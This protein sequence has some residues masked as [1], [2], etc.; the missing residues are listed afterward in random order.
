MSQIMDM[1]VD[2]LRPAIFPRTVVTEDGLCLTMFQQEF[3]I[4][5]PFFSVCHEFG[6]DY[7]W[8]TGYQVHPHTGI[9]VHQPIPGQEIFI[10]TPNHERPFRTHRNIRRVYTPFPESFDPLYVSR[11]IL[12]ELTRH[13]NPLMVLNMRLL[14]DVG[15]D[16][17]YNRYLTMVLL[18]AIG[19]RNLDSWTLSKTQTTAVRATSMQKIYR[20]VN[21]DLLFEAGLL[22]SDNS[23]ITIKDPLKI[24]LMNAI[25]MFKP[26][27]TTFDNDG[28]LSMT[29]H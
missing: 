10:S 20:S 17:P 6:G 8:V 26:M 4:H 28:I 25:H 5:S 15:A 3:Q 23:Q 19:G 27:A 12:S 24:M 7:P 14:T 22:S 16:H 2:R 21:L 11:G 1:A 9:P 13:G 29:N 18:V